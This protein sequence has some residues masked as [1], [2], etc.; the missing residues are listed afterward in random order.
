M[1]NKGSWILAVTLGLG[2]AVVCVHAIAFKKKPPKGKIT[3][4]DCKKKKKPV[5]FDHPAHVKRLKKAG[6]DCQ[7]C[8]HK[9]K[10]KLPAKNRCGDCHKKKQGK[11]KDCQ[12]MSTKKNP[13]HALCLSCHKKQ[14]KK[15]AKTK[16]PT[17]CKQCHPK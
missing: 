9:I 16:A 15:S 5:V 7:H 17:K 8:H 6:M 2:T 12:S 13:F 11:M 10:G 3:I 14:K 1:R 4:K